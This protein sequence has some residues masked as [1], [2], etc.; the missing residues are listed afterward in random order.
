MLD[1]S[2]KLEIIAK[3]TDSF[4][5]NFFSKQ[6]KNS[7]L[8]QPMKYGIFSGGKRFSATIIFNTGKFFKIKLWKN[9]YIEKL[10]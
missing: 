8:I 9:F 1:F 2:K 3:N 4:L 5:K 6:E 7:Y 10:P